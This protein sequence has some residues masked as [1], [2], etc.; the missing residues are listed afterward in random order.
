[1]G[2]IGAARA[3][4]AAPLSRCHAFTPLV[5]AALMAGEFLIH[6]GEGDVYSE[7]EACG[8]RQETGWRAGQ[9]SHTVLHTIP[10]RVTGNSSVCV[11]LT[12]GVQ[13]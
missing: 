8:W 5:L 4:L 3:R 9:R 6:T 10:L 1:M 12:M 7:E 13:L 2:V 11:A